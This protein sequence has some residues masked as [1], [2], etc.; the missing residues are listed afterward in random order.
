MPLDLREHVPD[1]ADPSKRTRNPGAWIPKGESFEVVM[2]NGSRVAMWLHATSSP[3]AGTLKLA[4][5]FQPVGGGPD[6]VRGAPPY[7]PYPVMVRPM[8]FVE[9]QLAGN[10]AVKSASAR[11]QLR[12][13]R[14]TDLDLT[15]LLWVLLNSAHDGSAAA[16]S[17]PQGLAGSV[18]DAAVRVRLKGLLGTLRR[19]RNGLIGHVSRWSMT[20]GVFAAVVDGMVGI[21]ECAEVASG[22]TGVAAAFRGCVEQLVATAGDLDQSRYQE[23]MRKMAEDIA[24]EMEAIKDQMAEMKDMMA[25]NEANLRQSLQEELGQLRALLGQFLG[26]HGSLTPQTVATASTTTQPRAAVT[27]TPRRQPVDTA[28]EQRA[29]GETVVPNTLGAFFVALLQWN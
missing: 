26:S 18:A 20:W 1:P 15:T 27:A 8:A 24:K 28:T 25:R 5:R 14:L 21:A 11:A 6:P 4:Q 2:P 9:R 3:N 23:G 12:S 7:R 17:K 29:R 10:S 16:D 13:G 22:A 19:Q